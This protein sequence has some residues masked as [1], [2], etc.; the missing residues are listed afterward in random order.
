[1]RGSVGIAEL[2]VDG[3][4]SWTTKADTGAIF[5]TVP[6]PPASTASQRL[7]VNFQGR[8]QVSLVVNGAVREHQTLSGDEVAK[9]VDW[10]L[11]LT[12]SFALRLEL[13]PGA[14]VY[15]F[16]VL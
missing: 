16:A 9:E 8:V 12:E 2:R 10:S 5:T 14:H 15:S 11:P 1:M 4:A 3:F 6:Q 13:T 7:R